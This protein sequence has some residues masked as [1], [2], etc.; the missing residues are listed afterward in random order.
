MA[1]TST[2]RAANWRLPMTKSGA[3]ISA[4]L[5]ASIFWGTTGLA[6]STIPS[7]PPAVIGAASMGIG[8]LLMAITSPKKTWHVLRTRYAW[9]A[10]VVGGCQ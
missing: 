4:I 7:I 3:A 9:F 5:F 6:A 1:K 8:G 10:T 2:G